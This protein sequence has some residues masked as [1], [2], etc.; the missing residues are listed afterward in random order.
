MTHRLDPLLRPK[1]IAIVGASGRENSRGRE[2]LQNLTRG[3]FP[4]AIYPVNPGYEELDGLTCYPGL[5]DLPETP[6]LVIFCVADTNVEEVLDDV[7]AVG[8]P[9]V[10]IMSALVID[11]DVE[12]N[13][14][15]RVTKKIGDAG[16]VASGANGMGFYNVRDRVWACGFDGRMHTPPGNVSLISHSGS[17]MCGIADCD[18]RIRFN[19]AVSTGNEINVT[20]AEYLDFALEQAETQVVGLFV[21]TARQPERFRAALQ[22]ANDKRIPI[23]AI[24]VGRTRKSAKLA[25]SHSG[26][27]AGDDAAYDALFDHYGVQRVR[28]MEELATALILFAEF[29]PLGK[30]SLVALH[31]SGGERQLMIDLADYEKV[32]LTEIC[33]ETIS[34][35]E[36]V[37]DPELPAVNPLDGWSR[38]G[39]DASEHMT[40]CL[41]ILLQDPG[42]AL[43]ALVHDR[44]PDAEIYPSYVNYMQ[45]AHAESGKPVALVAARQGTGA[46]P[47]VVT[48]THAGFP[49]IDGVST[50]L[51]GVRKLFSHRDFLLL[52]RSHPPKPP[53]DAV[54]EWRDKLAGGRHLDEAESLG[55]LRDFGI[56]ANTCV[57]AESESAVIAATG[58]LK[59]PLVLKTAMPGIEHKSNQAGVVLNIDDEQELLVAYRDLHDRLGPRILVAPMLRAGVE[60]ILGCKRDPQF[61]PIVLLGFGGIHAELYKDVAFGLPPFDADWA[62]RMLSRLKLRPL[63]DGM[64]G[65]NACNI[66]AFCDMAAKF[67]AMVDALSDNLAEIDINPVI[68]GE[69]LSIAV[70]ALAIGYDK[71]QNRKTP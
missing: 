9:A 36:A 1:S 4:G 59:Y 42:A 66:E 7:I 62:H 14:K 52:E 40:R 28:D 27:I 2:T 24:K 34:R 18:E 26:A 15:S 63:L 64:R 38:G 61:G 19:L 20:M 51:V 57:I 29:N 10:S 43:G 60:M 23:V 12:P 11:D 68:V 71:E 37:L 56:S 54:I 8:A 70:D 58:V 41:S 32:P 55:M 13:L 6:D 25:E 35:L 65:R 5:K 16:I 44:G 46:D 22:K 21:E 31:D 39:P 33:K 49:V 67:S 53:A 50:F 69:N 48:T 47:L 45:R 3:G 17:G 30:G